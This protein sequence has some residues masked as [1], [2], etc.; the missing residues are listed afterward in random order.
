MDILDSEA[1]EDE[2][3]RKHIPVSRPP[4]HEAN[5]ELIVKQ[6]QYRDLLVEAAKSDAIVRQKWEDSEASISNLALDEVNGCVRRV[7]RQGPHMAI[8]TI[9]SDRPV[10]DRLYRWK[11]AFGK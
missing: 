4:S 3:T 7:C 5:R 1:S 10:L 6:K 2:A 8:G 11:S 9:G